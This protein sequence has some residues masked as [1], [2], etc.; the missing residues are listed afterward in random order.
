MTQSYTTT[1]TFTRTDARRVGGKVAADLKQMQQAYG[2]PSDASI[3]QHLHELVELLLDGYLGTVVYGFKRDG[4]WLPGSLRYTALSIGTL[5]EDAR[6][7]SITRGVD[8]TGASFT[9]HLTYSSKWDDLTTEQKARYK[10]KLPF[11]RVGAEEPSAPGGWIEGKSYV[12][13]GGG[14]RRATVGGG[15]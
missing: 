8:I 11:Q 1:S 5:S 2:K 12:S 15:Q 13:S 14:V 6:S 4:V 9:S 10:A 7:G 3:E